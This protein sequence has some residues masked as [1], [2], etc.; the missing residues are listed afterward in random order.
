M[1]RI[2]GKNI[3]NRVAA[4]RTGLRARRLPSIVLCSGA[5]IKI[6]PNRQV[7][8]SED[9]LRNN[10]ERLT[11]T[12]SFISVRRAVAP[13]EEI[14]LLDLVETPVTTPPPVPEPEPEVVI[15]PE[16]EPIIEPE[17]TPEP[18][19][20]PTPEPVPEPEPVKKPAAKRTRRKRRTKA[21]IAADKA[22]KEK[23]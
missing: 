1:F 23:S 7:L 14:S 10:L 6:H 5:V 15:E 17:P 8:I 22:A 11:E 18:E 2:T 19:P 3:S 4:N 20:E 12:S 16:P 21:E 9:D 13:F